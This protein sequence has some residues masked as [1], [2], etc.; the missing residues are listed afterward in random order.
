MKI[1]IITREVVITKLRVG[2]TFF[3]RRTEAEEIGY[4]MIV[5][6]NSGVVSTLLIQNGTLRLGDAIVVGNYAGKIRTLK[7]DR[8][9]SLVEAGPS[10]PVSITGLSESPSAGV[11]FMVFENEKKAKSIANER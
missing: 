8:N 11:K 2:D 9:E 10:T 7:N 6:K 5:D 3:A 4:Y 1:D